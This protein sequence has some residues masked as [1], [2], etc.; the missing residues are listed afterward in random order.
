MA[1]WARQMAIKIG[2]CDNK[3]TGSIKRPQLSALAKI[4]S[5]TKAKGTYKGMYKGTYKGDVSQKMYKW[6]Y[7]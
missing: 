6:M 2:L 3:K 1:R 5:T 7:V 4:H